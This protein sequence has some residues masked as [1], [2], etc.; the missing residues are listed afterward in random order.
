MYI[1]FFLL[2][3]ETHIGLEIILTLLKHTKEKI[4]IVCY[5]NHALDQTLTGVLKETDEI[6][7]FG[8]Q[9]KSEVM[10]KYTF[11]EV[12]L[13]RDH[14]VDAAFKQLYWKTKQEQI[15]LSDEFYRIQKQEEV[16]EQAVL[17]KFQLEMLSVTKKLFEL[18]QL[19]TFLRVQDKRV[20][21]MTTTFAARCHA[22]LQLLE[23]PIGKSLTFMRLMSKI[24]S[25]FQTKI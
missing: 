19:Q 3:L 23:I 1:Y 7:R 20:F 15:V 17:E 2:I 21:G 12:G 6:I 24:L 4:L 5:T 10:Q 22:L 25:I 13:N 11:K 9:S 16:V 18:N 14:L 8:E